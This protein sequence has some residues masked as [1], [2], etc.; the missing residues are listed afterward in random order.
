MGWVR[1]EGRHRC[2]ECGEMVEVSWVY[3]PKPGLWTHTLCEPCVERKT[4]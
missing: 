3:F 1:V 2:T 4:K